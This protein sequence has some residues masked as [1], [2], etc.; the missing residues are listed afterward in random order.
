MATQKE[1]GKKPKPAP[2]ADPDQLSEDALEKVAG[3][4]GVQSGATLTELGAGAV[5]PGELT[6]GA[7]K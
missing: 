2:E 7:V 4:A 1:K 6:P 5:V 3:G